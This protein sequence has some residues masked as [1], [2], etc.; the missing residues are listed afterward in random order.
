MILSGR[1]KEIVEYSGLSIPK[2]S[3]HVGFTTPQTVRELINGRTKTLS[4]A[5]SSKILS[6][7]PEISKQW[8]ESG[9]GN[10]IVKPNIPASSESQSNQ[11]IKN[12]IHGNGSIEILNIG[13]GGSVDSPKIN[14]DKFL[15][16]P[17]DTN[18]PDFEELACMQ[19]CEIVDLKEIVKQKDSEIRE[20]KARLEERNRTIEILTNILN[21]N[22]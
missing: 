21:S 10:M 3:K 2:F 7:Y 9:K 13:K 8:L 18:A 20:L 5:V 16:T 1:I 17:E 12:D 4:F 11:G 6:A 22:K 15:P 19:N 14:S